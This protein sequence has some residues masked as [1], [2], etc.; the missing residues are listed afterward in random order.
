MKAKA[1]YSIRD[2]NTEV[3][4]VVCCLEF[5]AQETKNAHLIK[6]HSSIRRCIKEIDLNTGDDQN[7]DLPFELTDIFLAFKAFLKFCIIGDPV[8]KKEIMQLIES[9]DPEALKSYV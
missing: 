6:V 9:L 1:A 4:N 5:L 8:I 3:S 7:A 2:Y